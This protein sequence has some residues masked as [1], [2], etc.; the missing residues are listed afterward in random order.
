M[1]LQWPRC[2]VVREKRARRPTKSENWSGST[3]EYDRNAPADEPRLATPLLKL[4]AQTGQVKNGGDECRVGERE[5]KEKSRIPWPPSVCR[6]REC[7]LG[8][9]EEQARDRE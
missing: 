5:E 8:V 4:A 7:N 2:D 3:R 9:R 1:P 6:D